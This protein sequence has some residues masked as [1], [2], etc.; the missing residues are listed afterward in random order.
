MLVTSPARLLAGQEEERWR[1]SRRGKGL[2]WMRV[3]EKTLA[4]RMRDRRNEKGGDLGGS[5]SRWRSLRWWLASRR[6]GMARWCSSCG[7]CK[8]EGSV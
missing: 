8:E 3:E 5:G 6:G 7:P 4:P 2:S 1:W